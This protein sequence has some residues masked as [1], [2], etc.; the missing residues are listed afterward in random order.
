[1][2]GAWGPETRYAKA[3]Q[4]SI[5][6]QT[7]GTGPLDLVWVSGWLSNIEVFHE[8]PGYERFLER[9]AS[10][11]R[12]ILFD[13]RGVGLSDPV[14]LQALPTLEEHVD[15]MIAVL[16]TVRSERTVVL[17]TS[18][19][20]P[21]AI[22]FAASHPERTSA[23]VLLNTF[24]RLSRSDDYPIGIPAAVFQRFIGEALDGYGTGRAVGQLASP[25]IVSDQFT[26]EWR[27]RLERQSA[28]PSTARALQEAIFAGDVRHLLPAVSTPTLV[29]HRAGDRYV[30]VGHG[31]YLAEHIPGAQYVELIGDDRT[32]AAA[33]DAVDAIQEFLT[34]ASAGADPE[35]VLT[36]LLLTDIVESTRRAAE[37]GDA[38]WLERLD[39]HDHV[40]KRQLQRYNG[41]RVKNTG[42]GVLATFDGPGRAM[43]CAI[44][45][46]SGLR[47]IGLDSRAGLHT[48]EVEVHGDDI[49]G[50]AVHI[51]QRVMAHAQPGEVL[52]SSAIPPLVA[53]AEIRFEDRGDH[54]L[55]GIPSRWRLFA[56]QD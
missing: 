9:L 50:I 16:D 19:G 27:G 14:P 13:K 40:I 32:L 29:V 45:I 38:R 24:A 41:R 35:R 31:R 5:A 7:M 55:K 54:I 46:R 43:R 6:Y 17:G 51:A 11:S 56:V 20:G 12:L 37:L 15:D 2:V 4:L 33:S 39:R 52:V 18:E 53:G 8:H 3:G 42:D 22:M 26:L 49:G 28:S 25:D 23:L 36:T 48:G 30:R 10:F 21:L 34:G 47:G 44:A 1:L